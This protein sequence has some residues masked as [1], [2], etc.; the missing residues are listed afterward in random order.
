MFLVHKEY[1]NNKSIF[2]SVLFLLLG[3]I[4]FTNPEGV[5]DFISYLL[6]GII[7]VIG[8][9]NILSYLKTKRKLNI[10]NNLTLYFGVTL[11]IV[12][13]TTF[14]LA[15]LI[16]TVIRLI[17]GSYIIYTGIMRLIESLKNK[18]HFTTFLITLIVSILMILAGIYILFSVNLI[19]K[20]LGILIVVYA[21]LDI[22]GFITTNYKRD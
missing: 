4:L 22:T 21:I 7:I 3:I 19:Y 9:S 11:I 18:N 13:I 2:S 17:I 10:E 6:G 20:W 8:I 5:V 1:T 16:E 14:F 12:G 15:S